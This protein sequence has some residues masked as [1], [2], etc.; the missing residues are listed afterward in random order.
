MQNFSAIHPAVRK[1]FQK[2]SWGVA[3]TPLHGRGLARDHCGGGESDPIPARFFLND[4]RSVTGIDTKL[5]IPL[6][7]YMNFSPYT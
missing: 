6:R 3:S 7:T 1:P 2:N 4:F 5:G